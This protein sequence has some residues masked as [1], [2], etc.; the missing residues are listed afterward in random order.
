MSSMLGQE[1]T[2][3]LTS[4]TLYEAVVQEIILF[5]SYIWVM[6]PRIGW[7]LGGFHN[8]VSQQLEGIQQKRKEERYWEYLPLADDILAEGLEELKRCTPYDTRTPFP[9]LL[10]LVQLELC[11]E[12]YQ[13]PGA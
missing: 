5:G 13:R 9:S 2:D 10:R 6:T 3:A 4:G 11:M 1:G 12:T 7:A 8:I